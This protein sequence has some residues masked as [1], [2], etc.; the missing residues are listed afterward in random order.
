MA[1]FQAKT[2][3]SVSSNTFNKAKKLADLAIK[4]STDEFGNITSAGYEQAISILSPFIGSTNETTAIDAQRLIASYNT[5]LDKMSSKERDQNEAVSSFKLQEQDAYFTSADGD[6]GSFRNPGDL[7]SAASE[8]LDSL[9]IAVANAIETKDLKG[10]STDA[11]ELYLRD[12]SSRADA[13][14]DLD[15]RYNTGEL[16]DGQVLDGFG[17]YVETNPLDGTIK[18]A[19]V[20]PVTMLPS[21]MVKGYKRLEA[22][23]KL[24]NGLLPVYAPAVQ[25][26]DGEYVS[27]IGD[28]TWS[29]A[30]SDGALSK[31]KSGSGSSYLFKEGEF[32]ISDSSKFSLNTTVVP[33]GSFVEG[34]TGKDENGNIVNSIFYRGVDGTLYNV[35]YDAYEKLKNDPILGSKV[36]GYI[37]KVSPTDASTLLKEA[38]ALP[39]D[40]IGFESNVSKLQQEADV[41]KAEADRL[42]NMGFFEKVVEGSKPT[43]KKAYESFEQSAKNV[44]SQL[45]QGFFEAKN[46]QNVPDESKTGTEP[47]NIIETGKEFFKGVGSF[48]SNNNK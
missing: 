36:G 13:M 4:N 11:L 30:S 17:Y 35:G 22:T 26:A 39:D 41:S 6:Y 16:G 44:G 8:S 46:R 28:A 47:T 9:V 10:D 31:N 20:L 32:S 12:L 7:I 48:F 27:R 2:F 45:S 18:S 25:T 38:V 23:S 15:V 43:M 37:E 33:N 42:S 29:G 3:G 40:K 24:G 14:R 5:N 21:D 1:Y 19:A 34:A